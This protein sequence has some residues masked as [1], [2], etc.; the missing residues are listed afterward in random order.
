[1]TT[2]LQPLI[3]ALEALDDS[4]LM[5][6]D[7][8]EDEA[9]IQKG[10]CC[11]IGLAVRL[12]PEDQQQAMLQNLRDAVVDADNG[13]ATD[14]YLLKPTVRMLETAFGLRPG[15]QAEL[16][17]INDNNGPTYRKKALLKKLENLECL[18]QDIAE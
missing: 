12:L 6:G 8:F 9:N 17:R 18:Q 11:V 13:S 2:K 10:A 5:A 3:Q 4:Q 16:Q 1:M 7:Y 14:I 15:D